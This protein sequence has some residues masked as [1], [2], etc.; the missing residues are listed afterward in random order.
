[1]TNILTGKLKFW[2]NQ[3]KLSGILDRFNMR[4]ICYL[5]KFFSIHFHLNSE[6][7]KRY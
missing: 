6:W 7:M 3:Y 2:N 4:V 1:M 5:L